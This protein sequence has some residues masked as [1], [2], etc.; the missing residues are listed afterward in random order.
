MDLVAPEGCTVS[1]FRKEVDEFMDK[2]P[3][4]GY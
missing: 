2:K 4:N 1:V 3:R